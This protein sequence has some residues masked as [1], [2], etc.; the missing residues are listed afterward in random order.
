MEK[1]KL[2]ESDYETLEKWWKAYGWETPPAKET[3][4]DNATGGLMVIKN[5]KEIAACF[6]YFTNSKTAWVAWPISDPNYRED[7]RDEVMEALLQAIELT[8]MQQGVKCMLALG[9]SKSVINRH[10]KLNWFVDED[11]SGFEMIKL[12]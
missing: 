5:N 1:R 6:V 10:K 4:P 3:L 8:C 2:T 11:E 7:D 12:I 9:K